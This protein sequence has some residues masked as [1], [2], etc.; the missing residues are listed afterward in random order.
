ML[1]RTSTAIFFHPQAT[2]SFSLIGQCQRANGPANQVH[3]VITNISDRWSSHFCGRRD[4]VISLSLAFIVDCV[5][6]FPPQFVFLPFFFRTYVS[7]FSFDVSLH[8]D[9]L[10]DANGRC[11]PCVAYNH[12]PYAL[13]RQRSYY[14]MYIRLK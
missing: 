5:L 9:A 2:G 14:I 1:R 4:I 13:I 12:R 10:L 7:I 11:S 8:I 6:F 3:N